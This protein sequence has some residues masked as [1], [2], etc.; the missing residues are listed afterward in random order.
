MSE[1]KWIPISKDTYFQ[2]AR[3]ENLR[4]YGTISDFPEGSN[5]WMTEW[6][7]LESV[8]TYVIIGANSRNDNHEYYIRIEDKEEEQ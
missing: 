1:K 4:L 6:I 8:D 3:V 5:H 2:A 7:L